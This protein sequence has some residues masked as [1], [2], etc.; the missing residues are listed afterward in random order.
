MMVLKWAHRVL[1]AHLD[2]DGVGR[3]FLRGVLNAVSAGG[4][5]EI[6]RG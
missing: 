5:T 6:D 3:L 1:P 4:E 2:V